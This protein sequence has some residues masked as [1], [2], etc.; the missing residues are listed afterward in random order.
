PAE[1]AAPAK[2][3]VVKARVAAIRFGARRIFRLRAGELFSSSA[4]SRRST[5]L[6][7]ESAAARK[8]SRVRLCP[9]R[10]LRCGIALLHSVERRGRHIGADLFHGIRGR[11]T[12]SRRLSAVS[13]R[14]ASLDMGKG[15]ENHHREGFELRLPRAMNG[16]D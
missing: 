9:S 2:K 8:T 7:S 4:R 3:S 15:S 14:A 10:C 12:E 11:K 5:A 16:S 6:R 1:S 13:D